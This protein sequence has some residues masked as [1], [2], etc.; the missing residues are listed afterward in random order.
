MSIATKH[1]AGGK[2]RPAWPSDSTVSARF[3]ECDK[4][5]YEL[6]EIWDRSKPLVLWILM[7]PSVACLDYSDPTL[8]KTG[9]FARA[10]GYGGQLVGNVHAY[11]ATNRRKLLGVVDPVGP[12]NDKSILSMASL[13]QTVVLGY[14]HPPKAIK[15][16][17]QKVAQMLSHHP[18]LCYL[19]LAKDGITP[20][21]PLY[22]PADLCTTP[23]RE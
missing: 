18:A 20:W 6:S 22:L 16:R 5:R 17:G 19:K 4:Y 9:R 13:A 23:Y 15:S 12:E 7:N 10:W 21:H 1:D 2:S 3:S 11:R 14:G 8:R